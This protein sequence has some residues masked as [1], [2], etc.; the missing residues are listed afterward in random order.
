MSLKA[1]EIVSVLLA[2]P[3]AIVPL[4]VLTPV[5]LA[6][7]A[8]GTWIMPVSSARTGISTFV[9]KKLLRI[10]TTFPLDEFLTLEIGSGF[11]RSHGK[12]F[13]AMK[14]AICRCSAGLTRRAI[15]NA[16]S[17]ILR[18]SFA[19]AQLSTTLRPFRATETTLPKIFP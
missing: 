10:V 18:I 3:A 4:P 1:G 7:F 2:D 16:H 12:C 17:R 6:A 5:M 19:L 9:M 8:A 15:P 14:R 11:S 13:Q